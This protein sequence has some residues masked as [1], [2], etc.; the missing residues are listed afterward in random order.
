MVFPTSP[1]PKML[2]ICFKSKFELKGEVSKKMDFEQAKE[3]YHNKLTTKQARY[4][5]L[6]YLGDSV[7]DDFNYT[8]KQID[9]EADKKEFIKLVKNGLLKKEGE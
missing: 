9:D 3:I 2:L 1:R 5:M 8:I 6:E 4:V 7:W